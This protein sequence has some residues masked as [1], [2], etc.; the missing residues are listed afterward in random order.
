MDG[1]VGYSDASVSSLLW[2]RTSRSILLLGE[3]VILEVDNS[4]VMG[5]AEDSVPSA[6]GDGF[7]EGGFVIR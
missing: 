7:R 3:P 4:R 5:F 1:C 6:R 2:L